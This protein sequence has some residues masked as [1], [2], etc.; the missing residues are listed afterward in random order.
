[1]RFRTGAVLSSACSICT[2]G[3]YSTSSGNDTSPLLIFFIISTIILTFSAY[4]NE[5]G[6]KQII[7]FCLFSVSRSSKCAFLR[8]MLGGIIFS[9][10]RYFGTNP[11]SKLANGNFFNEICRV[12]LRSLSGWHLFKR[13]WYFAACNIDNLSLTIT[14]FAFLVFII[15]APNAHEFSSGNKQHHVQRVCSRNVLKYFG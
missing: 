9:I 7:P 13:N 6:A 14:M 4:T 3:T 12:D 10:F 15:F 1:M 2:A 8:P 11:L 5:H